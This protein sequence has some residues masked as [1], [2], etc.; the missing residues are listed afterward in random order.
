MQAGFRSAIYSQD[1]SLL[2][3]DYMESAAPHRINGP[4]VD[5]QPAPVGTHASAGRDCLFAKQVVTALQ[6]P[7]IKEAPSSVGAAPYMASMET[8]PL[9]HEILAPAD[10]CDAVAVEAPSSPVAVFSSLAHY[11][12][13]PDMMLPQSL[14]GRFTQWAPP[15]KH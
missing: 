10:P 12:G 15:P 8:R 5:W 2:E 14:C 3:V 1:L 6:S 11:D 7:P 9:L 4:I 13:T